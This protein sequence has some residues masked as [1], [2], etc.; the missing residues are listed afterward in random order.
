M[1]PKLFDRN[2]KLIFRQQLTE[3]T[4]YCDIEQLKVKQSSEFL[5]YTQRQTSLY[6]ETN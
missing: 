5:F 6:V 4:T 2:E 1:I 3:Q